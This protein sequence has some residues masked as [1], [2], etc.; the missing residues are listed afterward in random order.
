V[1]ATVG[2]CGNGAWGSALHEVLRQGG[3]DVKLW[4]RNT[5]SDIGEVCATDIL[6][7]AV[8]AHAMGELAVRIQPNL[9]DATIV[10]SAAKGFDKESGATMSRLLAGVFGEQ[11]PVGA[12]SGPNLA[13][14]IAAGKPAATVVAAQKAEIAEQVR[15]ACTGN[16]LRWYSSTDLIGV[17]YAGALKNVI[18]IAAGICDGIGVGDNGKSAIITRGLAEIARLGVSAGADA[19]TFA[20]LAGVGDCIATCMSPVSRN[21]SFGE[22]I[23]KGQ[24]PGAAAR[25]LGT[26]EGIDATKAA[27]GLAQRYEVEIPIAR[28]VHEVI[29]EGRGVADAMAALMARDPSEEQSL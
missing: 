23:A 4:G 7:L 11:Q 29:F 12:V 24:S 17:E 20:G 18:A 19:H 3:L 5:G 26:V 16:Q 22:A 14:E 2:I 28:A 9:G 21:R 1:S 8:P 13:S 10:I 27:L 6:I 25:E 15:D